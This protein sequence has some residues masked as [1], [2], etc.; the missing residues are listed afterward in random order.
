MAADQEQFYQILTSLLSTDNNI[1]TQAEEAYSNISVEGKVSHLLGAIRNGNLAEDARQI[2][3]VLLRRVF[4]NEFMDF[5]PKLPPESQAQLKEQV[6]LAVQ[7]VQTEQLRHKVCEVAAE[8]ARNLIDEEGNNQWPEFLQ[9]LFRYANDPNPVLKEAALA[10]FTSVP[11]VFGNQ[12]NN[13]LDLIKQM[14][15]QSLQSSAEYEVRFQAVRAIGAFILINDKETQILKHFADLLGPMLMVIAESIQ[16]QDD[17]TLLKVLIDLAENTP[18]YLR[19]QLLNIYDMCMKLFSDSSS[20]DSWRTLALEV[21]VTLAEMAPAMVR[22]N[23]SKYM[24][25]LVPLILLFMADLEEEENWAECDELLD[26]D[27]DCNNVVAE[28][29]LDRLA[30]GLGGKVILP[31]VT[32]NIPRMLN[33]PDWKQRHAALMAISAIGEGCHKHMESMLTQIMNGVSGV[34]DGVLRYLQ[35]PHP[36]VRYAACNAIGQ[37]STDFAPVFE[38]KFH[39]NVVPG[40]LMLLDDNANPRVQAHAG[41]ALVNFAEDCPKYILTP[42]LDPLMAKLEGILTSKVKELVEKGTKL[43]LEQVVTTIASVADTAE[44][45]FIA[46]YDRLMPCLK[47]IIENSNKEEYKLLRGKTIECVTLIGIAVGP[48]KFSADATQVMDM[49]L[50]THGNGIELPDD[51]PQTSYLISAWSRICKVLGKNFE[52]YLPLVMGPVMKTAAM[53]PDVALLD[54]DEMAGIEG[55][56]DDWQFVSL[57]EQKNF[58]IRTAGLEDKASACMMLVCYARELKDGFA[59]YAEETVKLMVPMLKFYFHDGVR[60]AAAESLPWL[61]ECVICKGPAFVNDMWQFICPELLRAISTEPEN[62]VLLIMLDSLARCIQKLGS[63]YLN[64]EYM[65]EILKIIDKLMTEHFERAV[66]RHKKHL[67]EDY[68]EEVQEQLEDEESDD[69]Y[70]LTKVADLIHSLFEVYRENFIPFFDQIM[71]HFINLLA[72]NRTWADRQWGICVF[73]DVIEFTGPA[74]SKYQ[75][76]FLEPLAVYIRDKSCE[77]RQAAAYGW[78]V[79]AQFGGE[80]F[81]GELAKIVPS[82]VEVINDPESKDTKNINATENTISAVTKIMKYNSSQINLN[83]LIPVWFSWLP[84]V[85]DADE[86]VHV[87]GYMCDL[88]EQNHQGVIGPNNSFIPRIIHIIAEAFHRDAIEA[89][90]PE[91]SRMLNIVRQVQSNESFFQSVVESLAPE[92][93]QALHVALHTPTP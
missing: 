44:N 68:D 58:G 79:L 32:N 78:G 50:K 56:D 2:S 48:E 23:A 55:Q 19:P 13:Y 53:K 69:I 7:Q 37:M 88:I 62:E 77:V 64:Q 84:V 85:E 27:N 59:P 45:E 60:N 38:K 87:Y 51:D 21:M 46:Y 4:S 12:Q 63:S 57:G 89:K 20:L 17:D 41:A 74:C 72:P 15:M 83:E 6:L 40:L 70:I 22:K 16:H 34:M 8:M 61:L 80:Q 92:L 35:D 33:H 71:N 18:K 28:A 29:A 3:A 65:T 30:C 24:G 47:Y 43:V 93:Q 75:M 54:S 73:D 91:G 49:L 11:G 1:R 52:P 10:M 82:L 36:R 81:A 26:E 25:E 66:D 67:D 76:Y 90:S 42:Y 5:Y 39:E 9:F 86:A 14:L 31:L